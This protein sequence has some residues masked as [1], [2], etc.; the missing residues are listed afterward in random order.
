M[1]FKGAKQLFAST[2]KL[3]FEGQNIL[4]GSQRLNATEE[5]ETLM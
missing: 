2:E 5:N 3:L 1:H 4:K